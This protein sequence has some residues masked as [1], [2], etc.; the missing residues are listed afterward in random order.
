MKLDRKSLNRM[1]WILSNKKENE[2]VSLNFRET[3]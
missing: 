3:R 2:A 1:L